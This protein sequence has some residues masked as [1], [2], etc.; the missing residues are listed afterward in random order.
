M[1]RFFEHNRGRTLAGAKRVLAIVLV[2]ALAFGASALADGGNAPSGGGQQRGG[3]GGQ[4]EMQTPGGADAGNDRQGS[5]RGGQPDGAGVNVDALR[6]AI[7]ALED[8]TVK[9]DLLVLLD[10]Y[11]DALDAKQTAVASKNTA[12]LAVLSQ[13]AED[14]K[15]ALDAAMTEAG[16]SLEDVLGAKEAPQDGTGRQ[17]G[18]P[19]LDTDAIAASIAALDDTNGNKATLQGL[20]NAYNAA[21]AAENGALTQEERAALSGETDAARE[22]LQNALQSA[23]MNEDALGD[24]QEPQQNENGETNRWRLT[25]LPDGEN[26]QETG[27][28]QTIY[29]WLSSLFG[30][31][32]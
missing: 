27:F 9:A 21:L 15:D 18:Q 32:D 1:K 23:G 6:E 4:T 3:A 26:A 13:L 28:L 22:A 14:A 24:A 11:M 2:L 19:A 7:E 16:L 20:L 5:T 8:E 25:I 29:N 17:A 10:A 31:Q 30:T 12:D